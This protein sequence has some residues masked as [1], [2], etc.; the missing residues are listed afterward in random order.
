MKILKFTVHDFE[1]SSSCFETIFQYIV[2]TQWL[3]WLYTIQSRYDGSDDPDDPPNKSA[4]KLI[5]VFHRTKLFSGGILTK[6]I[7]AGPPNMVR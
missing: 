2:I 5:R 7:T 4:G 1:F 3:R 6:L